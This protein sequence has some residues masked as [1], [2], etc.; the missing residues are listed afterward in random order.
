MQTTMNINPE[1]LKIGSV[2]QARLNMEQTARLLGFAPHVIPILVAAKLLKPLG[3][4]ARNGPK[5][6]ATVCILQLCQDDK[7][8][9]K[10][11]DATIH[12]WHTRNHSQ[13]PIGNYR[14]KESSTSA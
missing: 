12:Y 3:H 6:F 1:P 11:T 7:W 8:L 9:T 5:Y 2:L 14:R 10:A 4:P 13:A